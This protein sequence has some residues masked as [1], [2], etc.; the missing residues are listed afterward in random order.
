MCKR[1]GVHDAS[2]HDVSDFVS[3]YSASVMPGVKVA[4]NFTEL[5]EKWQ[6]FDQKKGGKMAVLMQIMVTKNR[7][8]VMATVINAT[9]TA[10]SA[11]K[12]RKKCSFRSN[13]ICF[14]SLKRTDNICLYKVRDQNRRFDVVLRSGKTQAKNNTGDCTRSD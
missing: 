5:H 13:N 11:E 12:R 2:A 9:M 10:R 3:G 14:G 8:M 1:F 7:Y 4:Q 6:G